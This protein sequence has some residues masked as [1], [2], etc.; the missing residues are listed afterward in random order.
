MQKRL[1]SPEEIGYI[2]RAVNKTA[3]TKTKRNGGLA[4]LG[5]RLP[6][7]QRV[8][9]SSPLASTIAGEIAKWLNAAD[10]NSVPSGSAV[11]ICLSP[12]FAGVVQW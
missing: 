5:E 2:N 6:Y 10:C 4:Q 12:P 7:K 1:A 11:R 9:G 8:S 3:Q